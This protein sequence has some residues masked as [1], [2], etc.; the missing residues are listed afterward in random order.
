MKKHLFLFVVIQIAFSFSFA[1]EYFLSPR[2]VNNF[3]AVLKKHGFSNKE[4]HQVLSRNARVKFFPLQKDI[5][6]HV[7]TGKNSVELRFFDLMTK[8][9][10]VFWK[11]KGKVGAK[12]EVQ[13]YKVETTRYR[14][15]VRG[16]IIGTIVNMTNSEWVARQFLDAFQ[17]DLDVRKKVQAGSSMFFV[18]EKYYKNGKFIRFGDLLEAGLQIDSKIVSR[19]LV[20]Y[21]GGSAFVGSDQN[22]LTRPFFSPVSKVSI[23]SLFQ[24]GRY[25][26]IRKKR[27]AHLGLDFEA[28]E[29]TAI[30]AVRSGYVKKV[31][32]NR[33]AGNYLVIDH[34]GGYETAY[35]HMFNYPLKYKVGR[36][37][38]AG[39]RIGA[40]GST[41][42][43]TR[44]HL[45]FAV[46][47]RGRYLDP[48]RLVRA[49]PANVEPYLARYI[50]SR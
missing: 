5:P 6:Y 35:N 13:N 14:A 47:Y 31:G 19:K 37:V 39:E 38:Q 24:N 4:Q 9:A 48:L 11:D 26:P 28:P 41:G 33:A 2:G 44:P 17:I 22:Y 27:Q 49:Y 23:S 1:A 36:K 12:V 8:D 32:Y 30:L 20:R 3:Y 25:H 29:G 40:V 45:H 7:K 21:P 16:S 10:L 15:I 42:Y 34:G 18:I 43:S 46:K 50:A